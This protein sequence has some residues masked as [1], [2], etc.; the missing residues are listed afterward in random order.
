MDE[1]ALA[2]PSVAAPSR[3]EARQATRALL[4]SMFLRRRN[5]TRLPATPDLASQL[6]DPF[7]V[8]RLALAHVADDL[9]VTRVRQA[10]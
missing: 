7:G 10:I 8:G 4:Y 2:L 6:D 1:E 3:V 5:S 9:A